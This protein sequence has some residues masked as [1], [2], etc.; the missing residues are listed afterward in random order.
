[1]KRTLRA[2]V[3]VALM[4]GALGV[5]ATPVSARVIEVEVCVGSGTAT[6]PPL[7]YP[8]LGPPANGPF[9][10]TMPAACVGTGVLTPLNA[11]GRL[12]GKINNGGHC[13]QSNSVPGTM[14]VNGHAAEYVSAGSMLVV[15]GVVV[16]GVA[17]A[18]PASGQSCLPGPGATAFT[19]TGAIVTA[20]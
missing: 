11:N 9:G 10:L 1:M 16:V 15:T 13:G 2:T 4:A 14:T 18:V 3:A 7:Y 8:A 19:V 17:N 12:T 6:T 5:M 20:P